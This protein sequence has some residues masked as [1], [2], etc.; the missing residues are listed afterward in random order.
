MAWEIEISAKAAQ[1]LEAIP[2]N[3]AK[4]IR[5]FLAHR[6]AVLDSPRMTGK[7]L[8]GNRLGELWRYRVADCR[9]VCDIQ[10]NRFVVLVVQIG[11]RREVYR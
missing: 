11:H 2:A 7:P 9:G 1:Q 8:Q 3:D 10:D 6:V 4:R 5:N